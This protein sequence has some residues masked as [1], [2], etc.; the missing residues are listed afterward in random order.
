MTTVGYGDKVPVTIGGRIIGVFIM[1]F[2][3]ALLS[4]FTATI[5]SIFITRQLKEG[6]G[7][8]QIKFKDHLVICGWNFNGEQILESLHKKKEKISVVLI[9]HLSEEAIA[10]ITNQFPRLKISFVKGDY[11]K[12]TALNR[13]NVKVANCVIIIPDT[14][15]G[16]G[17]KSDE[18][19]ILTTLSI[20]AISSKVKVYAH[21]LDRENLSHLRKAKVDDVLISD[22]YT[23]YLL[24]AHILTPGIPQTI[25]KLLLEDGTYQFNRK[26]VPTGYIGK[27]YGSLREEMQKEQNEV[28]IGLGRE[29]EGVNISDILSDDYSF[30]DQFIKRKFEEAGRGIHNEQEINVE[31]N[32]PADTILTEKDFLILISNGENN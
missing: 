28:F 12:E 3:V 26:E 15:A 13:A 8:E 21:I 23:G 2:G 18:R 30:L 20:K 11:T 9:N 22:A 31:I 16:L 4:L 25:D 17:S 6:R 24:A 29:E 5:S 1:F 32:P 10:D 27:T 7:L 14:S 19:T